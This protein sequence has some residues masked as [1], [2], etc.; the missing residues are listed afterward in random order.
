M[1]LTIP[2]PV[3]QR[4]A[5]YRPP[6]RWRLLAW[7]R[8]ACLLLGLGGIGYLFLASPSLREAVVAVAR[9]ELSPAVSFPGAS[10]VTVLVM[11]RDRDLNNRKQ[12]LNTPGRSDL[13]ML[14]RFA[15][16]YRTLS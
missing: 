13:M 10:A 14:A 16:D 5:P 15:F 8:R 7:L 11:G 1:G 6:Q 3:P 4:Y 9:G 2:R 12:V